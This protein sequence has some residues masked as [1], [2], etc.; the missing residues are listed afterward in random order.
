MTR[1]NLVA[2]LTLIALSLTACGDDEPRADDSST[3][4]SEPSS[5]VDASSSDLPTAAESPTDEAPIA[6]LC[7]LIDKAEL[8]R[9]LGV[10]VQNTVPVPM[11][12]V[13]SS[14]SI[15]DNVPGLTAGLYD[16]APDQ[17]PV[18]TLGAGSDGRAQ[19]DVSVAGAD[20]ATQITGTMAGQPEAY[21]CVEAER[22]MCGYATDSS[23]DHDLDQLAEVA[24]G[25]AEALIA[26]R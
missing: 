22:L 14:C 6:D 16:F 12:N 20:Q 13:G 11:E 2:V 4:R 15:N 8:A 23:G 26:S 9:I 25:L 19:T 21:V 10:P 24:H 17:V 5:S 1:I 18:D 3:P 7:T